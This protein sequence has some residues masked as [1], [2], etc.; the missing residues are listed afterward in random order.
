MPKKGGRKR[1]KVKE[2][3]RKLIKCE[4][5]G[6]VEKEIKDGGIE[7]DK[8][9]YDFTNEGKKGGKKKQKREKRIMINCELNG[10]VEEKETK[11]GGI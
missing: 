5:N 10:S 9:D 1:K 7:T 4:F 6:S 11:D 8:D 2:Q 3:K